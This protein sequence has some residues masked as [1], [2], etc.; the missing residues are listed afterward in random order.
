VFLL[1]FLT[2]ARSNRANIVG[3]VLMALV[4][5]TLLILTEK[6][7][8]VIGWTWLVL[9]GTFGT[10]AI[11]ALLAPVMDKERNETRPA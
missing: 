10:M 9:L 1:G 5:L 2:K 3:M 4:N 11:G 7:I 6:K 8:F